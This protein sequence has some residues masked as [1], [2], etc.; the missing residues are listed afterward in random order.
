M[1]N[2]SVT[3]VQTLGVVSV[4]SV[5]TAMQWVVWNII[6]FVPLIVYLFCKH[7]VV[8]LDVIVC[9]SVCE[10]FMVHACEYYALLCDVIVCFSVCEQFMVHACEYY[11]LLCDVMVCDLKPELRGV[12]RKF[13]LR[14]GSAADVINTN[15]RAAAAAD[16]RL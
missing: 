14:V 15:N 9:F 7:G 5:S 10:Q 4:D 3:Y 16:V 1:T 11:A 2:R 8:R 12:L 6:V 13:F